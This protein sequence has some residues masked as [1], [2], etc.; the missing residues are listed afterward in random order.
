MFR[1]IR[2][3]RTRPRP[4][5]TEQRCSA[6]TVGVSCAGVLQTNCS[7]LNVFVLLDYDFG[8]L[9]E[10]KELVTTLHR[11][12]GSVASHCTGLDAVPQGWSKLL[13]VRVTSRQVMFVCLVK[14]RTTRTAMLRAFLSVPCHH[15]TVR[16][17]VLYLSMALRR[18]WGTAVKFRSFWP[19]YCSDVR[20]KL[21][22]TDRFTLEEVSVV[23][24]K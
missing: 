15:L 14:G 12:A 11:A 9:T 10:A 8:R 7:S 17:G 19:W 18:M 2:C 4:T 21:Q 1:R 16:N 3:L 13:D 23:S 5:D 6:P 22:A 20:G 24:T